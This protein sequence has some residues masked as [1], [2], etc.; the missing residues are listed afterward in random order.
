MYVRTYVC[1]RVGM[2][3]PSETGKTKKKCPSSNL[4]CVKAVRGQLLGEG[5]H[6]PP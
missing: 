3:M 4:S 6:L 2:H 5:S 1:I